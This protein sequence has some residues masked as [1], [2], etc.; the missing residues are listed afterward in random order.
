MYIN[1]DLFYNSELS[2]DQ[3][4]QLVCIK[5]KRL[6]CINE[7]FLEEFEAK[8][9]IS[10]VKPKNKSQNRLELVRLSKEGENFL[11]RLSFVGA[12]DEET[13]ILAQWI[14]KEYKER[15]GGFVKNKA[16]LSRR[17]KWF[18]ETTEIKGNKL[19]LLLRLAMRDTY[20]NDVGMSFNEY[21]KQNPRAILSNCA[22][23]LFWTPPNLFSRHYSLS[24]SVLYTYFEDNEEYVRAVWD[25]NLDEN[26]NTKK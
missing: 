26:G 12:E 3:L 19:A 24:E 13:K 5:Q 9:L 8:E 4:L 15:D 14:I 21:K 16:E 17:I 10:Y 18:K 11:N 23:N 2:P 1:L 25:K 7:A 20:S 6:E 22:E